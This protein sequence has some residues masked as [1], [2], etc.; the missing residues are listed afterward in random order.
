MRGVKLTNKPHEHTACRTETTGLFK[1]SAGC[2]E[3]AAV[4]SSSSPVSLFAQKQRLSGLSAYLQLCADAGPALGRTVQRVHD[5]CSLYRRPGHVLYGR[6]GGGPPGP[7]A[8]YRH[9]CVHVRGTD[10]CAWQEW[11]RPLFVFSRVQRVWEH[12][13][14]SNVV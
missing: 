3:K 8:H 7:A 1:H 4:R 2:R 11:A 13:V 9:A 14:L 12:F 6:G 10:P 5:V